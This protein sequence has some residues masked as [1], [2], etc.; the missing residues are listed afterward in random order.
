MRRPNVL[1]IYADDHA[2]AA[3]SAYGSRLNRTPAI[4]RLAQHGMLFTQS[5]V[6]NSICGPA[7]GTLLTGLHSH[8]H[9]K[10][11]NQ[12]RFRQDLPTFVTAY[13][14]AG[15]Q[16]AVVGKW[17]FSSDPVG[18]DHWALAEGRYYG[19]RYRS[20]NGSEVGTGHATDGITD[21][22]IA[23]MQFAAKQDA[24]FFLWVSHKAAHR[25]WEPAV[26]HLTHYDDVTLE[27]PAT[28][29]D[30]YAGRSPGIREAQMR[31]AR[32]LF[33]AYDLKLPITGE[34]ILDDAARAMRANLN[35]V[36]RAAWE[37][38]YG[39]KNEAFA[40]ANLQGDDLVRWKYQRYMKDYL[41]CVDGLDE[42]VSRLMAA[43]EATGEAENTVV[44]YTSDQGFFLGEHGFYDKRWMYEPA[45]RTPLIISWPGHVAPGSRSDAL[46]QNVDMAPTFLEMAGLQVPAVMQGRSL[47]PVLLG[48]TP[49]DWRDDVYY[50]YF[51]KD[52]GRT[53]HTVARHSGVRTAR[54]KL[55]HVHDHD[56]W[57][58]YDLQEDSDEMHNRYDDPALEDVRRELHA[59]LV[60]AR[61]RFQDRD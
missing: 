47:V 8:L 17:H 11:T 23:W 52:E 37:A 42:S 19:T 57:E 15:Y 56:A 48:K 18:F 28:L 22:A 13:G 60:A 43:L 34:G 20:A 16:T 3:I 7:R 49:A 27:E 59:R 51:Q 38:A 53:N 41:R 54:Y 40:R 14:A 31:I 26:R 35:D 6:G 29:F 24:P 39:P 1:L 44:I 50:H 10:T 33:P 45:F 58:L 4:D 5:F 36:E 9:G 12:S 46:V 55:I 25:A 61:E 2:E 32:D 30:D 21:R